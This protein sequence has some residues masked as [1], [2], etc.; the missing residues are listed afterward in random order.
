MALTINGQDSAG[1]GLRCISVSITAPEKKTEWVNIPG[2]DGEVDLTKGI[3]PPRYN[4]RTV[5]IVFESIDKDTLTTGRRILQA[6][7]GETLILEL[8]GYDGYTITGVAHV[9]GYGWRP[10]DPISVAVLVSPWFLAK[11]ETVV[12]GTGTPEGVEVILAN[13]GKREAVPEVEVTLTTRIVLEG[14]STNLTP[15]K[16]LMP[17]Y[18]ITGGNEIHLMIYDGAATFRYREAIL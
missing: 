14:K 15:G 13:A 17:D 5:S 12:E 4:M 10:G 7:E 11:Q 18:M 1:Y 16:Y 6:W 3:C 9:D 8:P 2:G